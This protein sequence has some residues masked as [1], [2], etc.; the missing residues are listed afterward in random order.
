MG[1]QHVEGFNG[2]N[3]LLEDP[4][5]EKGVVKSEDSRCFVLFLQSQISTDSEVFHL[6]LCRKI[7]HTASL[8]V[9]EIYLVLD[10]QPSDTHP[11]QYLVKINLLTCY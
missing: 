4:N 9:Q 3:A 1:L 7:K 6:T 10:S 2:F 8:T 5:Q 11:F